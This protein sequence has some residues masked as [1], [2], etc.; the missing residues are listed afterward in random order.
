MFGARVP[1]QREEKG[2]KINFLVL[3]RKFPRG[4]VKGGIPG[5]IETAVS[6]GIKSRFID[7]GP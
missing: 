4:L 6:L 7:L 5:G 2:S 3:I 1:S